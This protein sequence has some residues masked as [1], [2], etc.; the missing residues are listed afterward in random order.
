MILGLKRQHQCERTDLLRRFL[1]IND[2]GVSDRELL[3][4]ILASEPRWV[5]ASTLA[6]RLLGAFDSFSKVI[7]AEEAALRAIPGMDSLLISRLKMLRIALRRSI[8]TEIKDQPLI[9]SWSALMDYCKLKI[10]DKTIEEFHVLF[11]NHRHA[12]IADELMQR[13]TVNHTPVYS[14]EI[15]K[16]GLELSA[17]A[18]VLLHNH[19]SGN[20]T[21]SE[22]D[23]NVTKKMVEAAATVDIAVHD[24]VI[25]TDRGHYSFKSFGQI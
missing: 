13:G 11:L 2:D 3:E 21:P 12:L 24:H 20:P 14:R 15:V 19:P 16:R 10:A 7:H 22:A 23:I 9:H 4:L 5:D 18:L 17:A 1:D 25:I 6:D 8:K